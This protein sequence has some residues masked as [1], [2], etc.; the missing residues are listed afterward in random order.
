MKGLPS[1]NQDASHGPLLDLLLGEIVPRLARSKSPPSPGVQS[2]TSIRSP[3][4]LQAPGERRSAGADAEPPS[5]SFRLPIQHPALALSRLA[6]AG[7]LRAAADLLDRQRLDGRSVA[8]ILLDVIQPAARELGRG[9]DSDELSFSDVTVGIGA[10]RRLMAEQMDRETA[11]AVPTGF[12]AQAPCALFATLPGCQHRLGVIMVSAIFEIA[13]WRSSVADDQPADR[14]LARVR[15]QRPSL[16]GLSIGS[17]F[18][19]DAAAEFILRARDVSDGFNP[20]IMVGGPVVYARPHRVGA[21]G[22]DIVCCDARD[23]LKSAA[24]YLKEP[25]FES[26]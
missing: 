10:M 19:I 12:A 1:G 17:D 25:R 20:V 4:R 26:I 15:E 13:G 16:F 8:D 6:V 21:I 9:W 24:R 23:A 18:E 11:R 7:N 22:A 5:P 3:S 2:T 14:L